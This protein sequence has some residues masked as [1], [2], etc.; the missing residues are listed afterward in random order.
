MNPNEFSVNVELVRALLG[1]E[2]L[3]SLVERLKKRLS[4]GEALTGKIQLSDATPNERTA[5]DKLMGRLP[6]QGSSLTIDLDRLS[7]ILVHAKVCVRLEE[8]V[9][10]LIGAIT[11]ERFQLLARRAA[12]EQL[13]QGASARVECN[14]A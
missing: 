7:D 9:V 8:A 13:W 10:A 5:I 11:D 6:T 12:W 14:S 1:G 3:Q 4:R 2:H